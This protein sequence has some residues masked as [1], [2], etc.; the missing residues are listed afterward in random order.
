MNGF[1][2]KFN[3][4]PI[5]DD[6]GK[7]TESLKKFVNELNSRN[8]TRGN[9]A[10]DKADL[11]KELD[12]VRLDLLKTREEQTQQGKAIRALQAQMKNKIERD[13]MNTVTDLVKLLPTQE[14]VRE[15]REHVA[16]NISSFQKDNARFKLDFEI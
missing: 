12:L 16:G 7:V 2:K 15:L 3:E 11:L 4:V 13:E 6:L 1:R 8:S 14:E 10:K 9:C 5:K